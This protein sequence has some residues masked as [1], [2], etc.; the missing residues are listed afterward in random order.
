M[1]NHHFNSLLGNVLLLL[2]VGEQETLL[3]LLILL[4]MLLLAHGQTLSTELT[5]SIVPSEPTL[6]EISPRANKHRETAAAVFPGEACSKRRRSKT[7]KYR[8]IP[9]KVGLNCSESLSPLRA[10]WGLAQQKQQSLPAQASGCERICPASLW[11][12][13]RRSLSL[14]VGID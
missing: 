9:L 14:R 12:I 8:T 11:F 6:A 7:Q 2:Y 1:P 5:L 10:A 3:L 4:L 13:H